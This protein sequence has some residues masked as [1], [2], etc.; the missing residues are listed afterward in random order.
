MAQNS[1]LPKIKMNT[2]LFELMQKCLLAIKEQSDIEISMPTFRRM[3]YKDFTERV[4]REGLELKF[5]PH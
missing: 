2:E 1:E 3:A 5:I 4:L